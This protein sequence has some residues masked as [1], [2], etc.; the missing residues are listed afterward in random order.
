[1]RKEAKM[2]NLSN[3]GE[4]EKAFPNEAKVT[5]EKR[6]MNQDNYFEGMEKEE[7][8]KRY[9]QYCVISELMNGVLG[10]PLTATLDDFAH[11]I[12]DLLIAAKTVPAPAGTI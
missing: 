2:I 4:V 1:M 8:A 11:R 3:K 10:L 9:V 6:E 7:I 12:Q 5:G